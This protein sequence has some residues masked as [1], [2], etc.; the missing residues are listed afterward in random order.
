MLEPH[1]GGVPEYALGYQSG[2]PVRPGA[3]RCTPTISPYG[4]GATALAPAR[5]PPA[6][7]V[8]IRAQLASS[9]AYASAELHA[10]WM[11]AMNTG[12]GAVISTFSA[13]LPS[14]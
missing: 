14:A 9:S 6:C 10:S 13:T 3:L 4:A 12:H 1:L 7:V 8:E 11:R 5:I 2:E